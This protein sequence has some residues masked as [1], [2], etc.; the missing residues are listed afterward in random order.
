MRTVSDNASGDASVLAERLL[1]PPGP[2][3]TCE[4]CF[5]LL[6]AY[7]ESELAGVSAGA[8]ASKMRAHLLGC[9]ACRSDHDSLLALL[10][11]DQGDTR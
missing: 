3:L 8:G 7:V 1:G 5:D 11:T 4:E 10:L 2:E 6:D 9:S